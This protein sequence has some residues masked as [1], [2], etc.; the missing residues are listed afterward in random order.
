MLHSDMRP[1]CPV[2]LFIAI[3]DGV[4]LVHMGTSYPVFLENLKI[5]LLSFKQ[6]IKELDVANYLLHKRVKSQVQILYSGLQKM[7]NV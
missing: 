2:M 4:D 5:I 7:T 3:V 6:M 1:I